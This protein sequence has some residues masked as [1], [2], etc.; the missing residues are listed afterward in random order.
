[1]KK[2]GHCNNFIPHQNLATR[3]DID[4]GTY[5][6]RRYGKCCVIAISI[7]K[8]K[9]KGLLGTHEHNPPEGKYCTK[10]EPFAW[11]PKEDTP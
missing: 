3:G 2:C 6:E 7:N 4:N 8:G 1:M 10:F 11:L 9:M 5:E